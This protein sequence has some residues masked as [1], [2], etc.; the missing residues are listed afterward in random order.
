[1]KCKSVGNFIARTA[2]NWSIL[3]AL[4]A[5]TLI[6]GPNKAFSANP[7][8]IITV[9]GSESGFAGDGGPAT[10]ALISVPAEITFDSAGNMFFADSGNNRIRKVDV[11]GIVTTVAGNGLTG[12]S[13]DG[14]LATSAKIY[15]PRKVA[16]DRA[17]NMYIAD[18]SNNRVRKVNT[19]G[20]I[21]TVAGIGNIGFTGD[22]GPATAAK[23]GAPRSLAFDKD[24]NLLIVDSYNLR[25][26]KVDSNG[27]I[28]TVV[29]NGG[30]ISSG[31]GGPA[32]SASLAPNSIVVDNA[33]NMFISDG[34]NNSV[35]KIDTNGIITTVAGNGDVEFSGDGGPATGA[36]LY[37][38]SGVAV[39]RFGNLFIADFFNNR[40][41]M[42]DTCGTI[43]TIAGTGEFGFYGD[44]GPATNA[45]LGSIFAVAVDSDGNVFISDQSNARI[46]KILAQ[47]SVPLKIYKSGNGT[48]AVA[49]DGVNINWAHRDWQGPYGLVQDPINTTVTVAATPG[50]FSSFAGWS[51]ACTGTGDCTVTLD[52]GRCVTATFNMGSPVNGLCGSANGQSLPSAP[53]TSLCNAGTATAVAGS[54]PWTW[55]CTGLYGGKTASC[56]AN[57]STFPLA[58]IVTGSGMVHSAPGTDIYC[59]GGCSQSYN[60]G[61]SLSLTA[62]PATGS[63]FTGWTG[64]CN[65]TGTCQVTMNQP[66]SVG[67]TFVADT[68]PPVLGGLINQVIEATSPSG[69]TAIFNVRATDNFDPAPVVT[70]SATSGS[71]FALGITTITCTAKDS[72]NNTA[73]GSFT[74]KVQDTTPPVLN[75]P[76]NITVLLNT[77]P[78]APAV[79]AFL[80]GALAT[81]IVDRSVAITSTMPVL[82]SVGAKV[83][84]FTAVDDFG[85]KSIR[86]ATINVVYGCGDINQQAGFLTPVSL[87]KPFKLGST[88]PVKLHL[89]DANGSDVLTAVA[90][91]YLKSSTGGQIEGTSTSGADTGNL[92]R[93]SGN[94]YMYNLGTK[95]LSSGTYQ[96][97][98]LLDDGTTRT[99]PLFL[100]Q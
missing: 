72:S 66:Q 32:I 100:R 39:D 10:A 12:F 65:G 69:A 37:H 44:G 53:T 99:I 89:C 90:R 81:D 58:V 76:A 52:T 48:G 26:R 57:R 18:T 7:G 14:G 59:S 62:S 27:I 35:R 4:M 94:Y 93:I 47:A 24:G 28:T 97:Q 68:T 91:L 87:L 9:V 17:G 16:F 74:I 71:T 54:G 79:Q 46:R 60:V 13:G 88:I 56:S 98:A 77:E 92:F 8:D 67:A 49:A 38:P 22:G 45:L 41:R 63:Y 15:Q 75:V 70:C 85:N 3:F 50:S 64:A 19:S 34:Y 61:S 40:I 95:S 36:S 80:N 43:T 25:I 6:I 1:M 96:L 42:V 82:N 78:T 51:G 29:G 21:S 33:G 55:S 84:T 20:I 2:I 23:I 73:T 86:T 5:G 30:A 11:N 31:D 83:V